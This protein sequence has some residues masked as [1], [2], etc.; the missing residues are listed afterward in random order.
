MLPSYYR[1]SNCLQQFRFKFREA[2]YRLDEE[3]IGT[4]VSDASLLQAPVRPAWCKDCETVTIVEDIESLRA[5]ENACAAVRNGRVIEYPFMSEHLEAELARSEIDEYLNW[6]MGRRSAPRALCCGGE[7]YQFMDV[8]TPLLKHAECEYGFVEPW[9][10]IGSCNSMP[11]GIR[12]PAN[13]RLYSSEGELIGLL[14]WRTPDRQ[15]WQVEPLA[16][17]PAVAE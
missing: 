7:N 17:P 16:Y 1:C 11:P 6:R 8:A 15:H 14:T 13:L 10:W 3:P 5:F 4:P 12:S 2:W 9:T